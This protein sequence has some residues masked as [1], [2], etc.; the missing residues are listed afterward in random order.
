MCWPIQFTEVAKSEP[1]LFFF[2]VQLINEFKAP[3]LPFHHFRVFKNVD[4]QF[5]RKL[6]LY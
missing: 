4:P 1:D 2:E 6:K 5:S 3:Y